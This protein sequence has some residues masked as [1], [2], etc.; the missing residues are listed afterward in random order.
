MKIIGIDFETH[1]IC[2]DCPAPKPVCLSYYENDTKS[3]DVLIGPDMEKK[4]HEILTKKDVQ[5]I[6]HNLKF[7][8]TVIHEHFPALREL[9]WQA[10]ADKRIHCTMVNEK[11]I[12]NF[13]SKKAQFRFD[14][15]TLTKKYLD[16][17]IAAGKKEPDAWRLRYN[18]LEGVPLKE[19]PKEAWDYA[20]MDSVYTV[21]IHLEHLK[22]T[23]E[24]SISYRST[25]ADFVLALAAN[26][27]IEVDPGRIKKL[28]DDIEKILQPNYDYLE[29]E[30]FVYEDPKIKGK[31]KKRV[32]YIREYLEETVE[33]AEYT[34]KKVMKI[35]IEAL[36][37]YIPNQNADVEKFNKVMEAMK[38]LTKYEKVLTSF[39]PNLIHAVEEGKPIR[40][41]YNPVVSTGRTSSSKSSLYPSCNVQQMPRQLEG[42]EYDVRN[43]FKAREGRLLAAID[44]GGLEL[45]S[46][47][48]MLHK[49]Y[50][51]SNM[52]DL[53]NSGETPTDLHSK[54]AAEVMSKEKGQ[55]ITYEQFLS[56]KKEEEYSK[57]RQICK[58]L[59]LGF[60]GGIGYVVMGSQLFKDGIEIFKKVLT[61][62]DGKPL[63]VH[64]EKF[65]IKTLT[66]IRKYDNNV[67]VERIGKRAWIFIL[68]ELVG[69]K[70]DFYALYPELE[71][72]LTETHNHF[73]TGDH[74]M[75][76]NDFG[77]W[78]KEPLYKFNHS[79][80]RRENATYT[81]FCNS[82]LMQSPSAEG[83]KQMLW[84]I[85][86]KIRNNDEIEL[87]AFIHDEIVLEIKNNENMV[88]NVDLISEIMIDSMSEVIENV[89]IN[90]EADVMKYWSKSGDG[91]YSALYW[92]NA[93]DKELKKAQ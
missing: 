44:Y 31:Y 2:S 75:V 51:K 8:S 74:K 11:L 32:K 79:G 23:T 55:K 91:T 71:K 41:S 46:T 59:N 70:Q 4:L 20:Y 67:R 57:Y 26:R 73:L 45:C 61:K 9:L 40:T 36:S 86:Y 21:K 30:G 38:V 28:K 92:K 69:L 58:A 34:N 90:V 53:L 7:E 49:V 82:F 39:A 35:G 15:A 48:S 25:R 42:V 33:N 5:I 78:E 87:L 12:A 47:A 18:E 84:D 6:A 81:Q 22:I 80:T 14:L 17:D 62:E 1:P 66:Q 89:R 63:L 13:A 72:F 50:K 68:D 16:V 54:F 52:L 29:K 37:N 19:W 3:G 85:G 24:R 60:P 10:Y 93:G 43:C 65:A 76:K 83:A 77:E 27:G 64:N 56:N 88:K